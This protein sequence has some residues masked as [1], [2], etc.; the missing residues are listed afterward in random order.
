[1]NPIGIITDENVPDKLLWEKK[2]NKCLIPED[3]H[4]EVPEGTSRQMR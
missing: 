2:G 1:M 3:L 4:P